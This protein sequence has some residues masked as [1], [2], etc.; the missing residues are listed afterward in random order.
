MDKKLTYALIIGI[1]II[2]FS[3]AYYFIAFLPAK[4]KNNLNQEINKKQ[5][6][7]IFNKSSKEYAVM[8]RETLSSFDC[9]AWA[10]TISDTKEAERLFLFGYAQGKKFISALRAEKIDKED[11]NTEVPIIFL[12]LLQGPSDDFIL[13]RLLENSQKSALEEVFKTGNEYNSD[14]MK[15]NIAGNKFRD[16]NCQLIGR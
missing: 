12:M 10:S 16:G 11:L 6:N 5:E 14:E 8:G 1:L 15:K 7:L 9:S 3:I 4:E 13:G 2:S